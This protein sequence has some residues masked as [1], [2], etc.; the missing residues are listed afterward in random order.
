MTIKESLMKCKISYHAD[1]Y[2]E[3]K[4]ITM[5]KLFPFNIYA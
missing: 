5:D 4:V 2:I 3:F 1:Y